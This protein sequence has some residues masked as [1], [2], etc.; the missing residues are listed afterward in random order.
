M[1]FAL[2]GLR[3]FFETGRTK[4]LVGASI[5]W[6]AQNLSCGYY[7]I[8]FTPVLLLYLAWELTVRGLW[9][10]RA[11]MSRLLAAG[12]SVVLLT[13]PFVVPYVRLRG[14]GFARRSLEETEHFAA[15]VYGYF[16]ADPNLWLWGNL[17]RESPR[18]EGALFPGLTIVALAAL[19]SPPRGE[20]P[21]SARRPSLRRA[22][23]RRSAPSA[24]SSSSPVPRSWR[25]SWA[26]RSDFRF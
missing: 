1:P 20:T 8:F 21:D 10:R 2:C 7:L 3:R 6:T 15:D 25:C 18:P 16:T 19:G 14:M 9:R 22:R 4:P 11:T 17:L 24:S 26:G 12:V 5:A 13:A 23:Q